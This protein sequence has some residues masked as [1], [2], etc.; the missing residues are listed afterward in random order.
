MNLV[1]IIKIIRWI[2][3]IGIS[4]SFFILTFQFFRRAFGE[5]A[6]KELKKEISKKLLDNGRGAQMRLTMSKYGVM[7]HMENYNMSPTYYMGFRLVIGIAIFA[8]LVI[9]D[10]KNPMIVLAIPAGYFGVPILFKLINSSDNKEMLIDIFN[11]YANINIQLK[12]GQYIA[13]ALE[14]SYHTAKSK[15]YKEAMGELVLNMADKTVTIE[16]SIQI[17]QNRFASNEI[18]KLCMM[19]RTLMRYGNNEEFTQDL[20]DEIK[21]II[22]ADAMQA[23]SDIETKASAVSFGFFGIVILLVVISVMMNF[24]SGGFFF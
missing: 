23:Q 21:E 22:Q 11:T 14:Y 13:N 10:V 24:E 20:L 18:D 19:L 6:Q 4:V 16:E 5:D 1:L 8:V 2:A 3:I 7:Y 9:F 15:R 17:F 12:V